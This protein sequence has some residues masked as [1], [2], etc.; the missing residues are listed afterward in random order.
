MIKN[1]EYSEVS[2]YLRPNKCLHPMTPEDTPQMKTSCSPLITLHI[3]SRRL[4]N[5]TL[6]S[7]ILILQ[8]TSLFP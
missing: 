8:A 6:F 7:M 3:V 1:A 4:H 5:L 2:H